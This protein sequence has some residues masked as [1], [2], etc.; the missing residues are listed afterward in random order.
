MTKNISFFDFF[1]RY[2]RLAIEKCNF[3]IKIFFIFQDLYNL[4]NEL[5]K[6]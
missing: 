3:S 5:Y 1:K 4:K 6:Q 2:L